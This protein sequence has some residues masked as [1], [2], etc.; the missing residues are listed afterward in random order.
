MSCTILTGIPLSDIMKANL[1]NEQSTTDILSQFLIQMIQ[2]SIMLTCP[3]FVVR[4]SKVF[5]KCFQETARVGRKLTS[6]VK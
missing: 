5:T 3:L 2:V 4:F 6:N 1:E